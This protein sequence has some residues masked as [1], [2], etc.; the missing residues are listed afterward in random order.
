MLLRAVLR[1]ALLCCTVPFHVVVC[2]AAAC[3]GVLHFAVP[4]RAVL[5]H[6][7][8]CRG[9]PCR[10]ALSYGVLWCGALCCVVLCC[11][12]PCH[13]G[14]VRAWVMWLVGSRLAWFGVVR[15]A[16]LVLRGLGMPSGLGGRADVRGVAL[17]YGLRLVPV[18]SGGPCP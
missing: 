5:W 14:A 10:V 4:C 13:E 11:A 12:A 18:P 2:R 6:A 1:C 7:V 15:C 16:G 3:C 8:L 17:P 9:V